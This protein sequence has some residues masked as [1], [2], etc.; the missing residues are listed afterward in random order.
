MFRLRNY[1]LSHIKISYTGF[2][3]ALLIAHHIHQSTRG[4]VSLHH[5]RKAILLEQGISVLGG[6]HLLGLKNSFQDSISMMIHMKSVA[7]NV[8]LSSMQCVT[9]GKVCASREEKD[10]VISEYYLE[11]AYNTLNQPRRTPE[12][13]I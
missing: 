12:N 3:C 5:L 2:F 13:L 7:K 11:S 9:Q 10:F 4:K 1:H 8:F 6:L